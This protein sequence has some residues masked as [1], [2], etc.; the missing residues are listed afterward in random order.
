[1]SELNAF[2]D[3]QDK[4]LISFYDNENFDGLIRSTKNKN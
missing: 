1:M 2:L 3:I 4:R